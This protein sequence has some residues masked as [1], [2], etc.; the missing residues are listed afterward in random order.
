[1]ETTILAFVVLAL[2]MAA[3]AVGVIVKGKP[4]K[5]SCGGMSAM[6]METEC[7]VCGGDRNRCEKEEAGS[8]KNASS[9]AS[10]GPSQFSP[11]A[12]FYD[13]STR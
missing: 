1:M 5:G 11:S 10:D 4:I 8:V 3:M 2:V 7:D 12:P 13:A 9:D 6:G